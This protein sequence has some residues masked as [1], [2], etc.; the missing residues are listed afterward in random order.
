[1]SERN[2]GCEREMIMALA[3]GA[4]LAMFVGFVLGWCWDKRPGALSNVS[5]LSLMTAVG[6]LGAVLIA[7]YLAHK[8]Q[9]NEF[10][11][12]KRLLNDRRKDRLATVLGVVSA[13]RWEMLN[14]K[15]EYSGPIDQNEY[16]N[17]NRTH[18]FIYLL[19]MLKKLDVS[20]VGSDSMPGLML[21]LLILLDKFIL[22]MNGLK[23]MSKYGF[24]E[25]WREGIQLEANI[26]EVIRIYEV[27]D[28]TITRVQQ[29]KSV[30][31]TFAD[32]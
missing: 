10:E 28:R 1:M 5:L 22:S 15:N 6:T 19:D 3:A 13:I 4:T 20:E 26:N 31:L 7:V 14:L 25:N 9:R 18:R 16:L 21:D 32:L 29:G 17:E 12:Q 2:C 30:N 23:L 27:I 8:T 24:P 11:F